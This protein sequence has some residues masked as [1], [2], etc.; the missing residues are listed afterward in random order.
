MRKKIFMV[1]A[2]FLLLATFRNVCQAQLADGTGPTIRLMTFTPSRV[3]AGV[4]YVQN[5]FS[6]SY[7]VEEDMETV[8]SSCDYVFFGL[9]FEII[10]SGSVTFTPDSLGHKGICTATVTVPDTVTHLLIRGINVLGQINSLEI[11]ITLE[12]VSASPPAIDP[13]TPTSPPDVDPTTPRNGEGS[14]GDT[15]SGNTEGSG[16]TVGGSDETGADQPSIPSTPTGS[17]DSSGASGTPTS[18]GSGS[19]GC[20]LNSFSNLGNVFSVWI[21]SLISLW[22]LRLRK[23]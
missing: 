20:A 10:G 16:E 21:F 5:P 22:G 23:K 17:T 11:P 14:G 12:H 6:F 7:A 3:E 2:V 1:A 18:E 8:I 9:G 19:G 13:G 15:S 4:T